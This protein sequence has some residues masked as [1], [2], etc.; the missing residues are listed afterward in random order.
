MC[1]LK[2]NKGE[3]EDKEYILSP[4]MSAKSQ[5]NQKIIILQLSERSPNHILIYG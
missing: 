2:F 1:D 3:N 4:L 5:D